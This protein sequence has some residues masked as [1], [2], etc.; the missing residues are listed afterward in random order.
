MKV[1]QSIQAAS[2]N[3]QLN[4]QA[5]QNALKTL[6][7]AA[8]S[9][10]KGDFQT[11]ANAFQSFAGAIAK[12]GWKPGQ[13]PTPAQIAALTVAARSLDQPKLKAAETHLEAW[14]KQNCGAFITTTG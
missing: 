10:I 2:G 6:A 11:F 7:A 1:S 13:T 12:S 3:G 14:A 5:E 4:L 9:A 8:P